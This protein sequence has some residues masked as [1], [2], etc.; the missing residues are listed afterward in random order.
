MYFATLA[1]VP[2]LAIS[3]WLRAFTQARGRRASAAFSTDWR[4]PQRG[5]AIGQNWRAVT[6]VCVMPAG[7]L[8]FRHLEESVSHC[9]KGSLAPPGSSP[10]AD[11]PG[12]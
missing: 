1:F 8:C 6:H 7:S 4:T 2:K 11:L 3:S 12:R 5:H 9:T 10:W